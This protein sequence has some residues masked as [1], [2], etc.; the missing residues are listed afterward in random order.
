MKRNKKKFFFSFFLKFLENHASVRFASLSPKESLITRK[1][2][3]NRSK[4]PQNKSI[5]IL[6]GAKARG[7]FKKFKL[8]TAQVK[9]CA[10][11]S[12]TKLFTSITRG[13]YELH[14]ADDCL[15]N[16]FSFFNRVARFNTRPIL[17]PF[18]RLRY[19]HSN[20]NRSINHSFNRKFGK[21]AIEQFKRGR[22]KERER[23]KYKPLP[24]RKSM[25]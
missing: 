15:S 23:E 11:H 2:W 12:A 25:G 19:S 13:N 20:A 24:R 16:F 5:W 21:L 10:N 6:T 14:L 22:Q 7:L 9:L 1:Q 8:G 3:Q 4:T 17:N 18:P